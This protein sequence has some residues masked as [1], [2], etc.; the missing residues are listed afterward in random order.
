MKVWLCEGTGRNEIK[1]E[2]E[3]EPFPE[4]VIAKLISNEEIF[5][6]EG[7]HTLFSHTFLLQEEWKGPRIV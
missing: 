6:L 5:T 2:L 4:N 7:N 3:L 1:F